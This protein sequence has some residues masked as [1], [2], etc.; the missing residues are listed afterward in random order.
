MAPKNL[1]CVFIRDKVDLHYVTGVSGIMAEACICLLP[2]QGNPILIMPESKNMMYGY[3]YD[4]LPVP[5]LEVIPEPTKVST[6][7]SIRKLKELGLGKATIGIDHIQDLPYSV[8]TQLLKELPET[9]L[10]DAG[11]IFVDC[12][13]VK[14]PEEV[15]YCRKAVENGEKALLAIANAAKPGV[16]ERELLGACFGSL[17]SSGSDILDYVYYN[18]AHW[19]SPRAEGL[20]YP[21]VSVGTERKLQTGDIIDLELYSSFCTYLSFVSEPIFLGKP[22]ADLVKR[23]EINKEVLR[24]SSELLRP[25][26]SQKDIDDKVAAYLS[27]ALGQKIVNSVDSV[28]RPSLIDY[29]DLTHGSSK[30][31]NEIVPNQVIAV[32]PLAF[33]DHGPNHLV[34]DTYLTTERAPVKL[35]K[36]PAEIIVV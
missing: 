12:S 17:L 25:G 13:K 33:W 20:A 29:K 5:E 7:T 28:G 24:I 15:E 8:Y 11:D 23:V 36:L 6:G 32:A 2:P 34:A 1:D 10:V 9:K 31:L 26:H 35:S 3:A 19:P 14:S 4:V 27:S 18:T 21:Y 22:P 16:T 30:L